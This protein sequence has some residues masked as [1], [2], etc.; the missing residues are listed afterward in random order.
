MD[1]V[2]SLHKQLPGVIQI[3]K[4]IEMVF[5]QH[6]DFVMYRICSL[7]RQFHGRVRFCEKRVS[8][9][10]S[11]FW[12][13]MTAMMIPYQILLIPLFK[14]MLKFNLVDTYAGIIL[15]AVAFPFGIFLI[16]QFMQTIPSELLDAA[17]I[18]GFREMQAFV[19]V[20]LPMCKPQYY[21]ELSA[22]LL[23]AMLLRK[24]SR[25][26][27]YREDYPDINENEFRKRIYILK[28]NNGKTTYQLM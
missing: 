4:C 18:D 8:L 9:K 14:L 13:L 2:E 21:I 25:G 6:P 5:Q 16:R 10:N 12:L 28:G 7:H 22:I 23:N 26:P 17:N 24:E 15:P 19:K 27:H 3:N 20:M 11:I 1:T